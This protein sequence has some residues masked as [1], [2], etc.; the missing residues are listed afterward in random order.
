VG[1]GGYVDIDVVR[2]MDGERIAFTLERVRRDRV[3]SLRY[4]QECLPGELATWVV[5]DH[6]H[7]AL[8][9]PPALPLHPNTDS[10]PGRSGT[11]AADT[12][13]KEE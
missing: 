12:D 11:G 10:C 8:A 7:P 2:W 4:E 5:R 9:T 1:V 13:P 6:V 3:L